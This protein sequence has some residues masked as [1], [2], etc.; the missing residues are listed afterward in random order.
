MQPRVNIAS[1]SPEA[2]RAVAGLQ[3]FVDKSGLEPSLLELIKFRASQI[4]GCAYCLDM[5]WKDAR[6]Q[7][8][9]EQ[10]LYSLD[11][12]RETPFYTD[13]ERTALALTESVTLVSRD[14]VPD[15]VYEQ[16]RAHF[17]EQEMV[18]LVMAIVAINS[19]NRLAITFRMPPGTYEPAAVRKAG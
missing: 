19:W 2:Y 6:A 11:A 16:A 4:N 12:W 8:E 10:R 13:R 14:H 3:H 1:V 9:S 5:H 18:S 15:E 17:S 7:G